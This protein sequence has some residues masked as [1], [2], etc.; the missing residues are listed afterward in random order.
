MVIALNMSMFDYQP[1]F[2]T[3][4]FFQLPVFVD[5]LQTN[6]CIRYTSVINMINDYIIYNHIL[7]FYLILLLLVSF[8]FFVV[9]LHCCAEG[10]CH[11]P[12]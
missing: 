3:L 4:V 5:D 12:T 2:E 11:G 9:S 1:L 6:T 10:V 8:L 7:S